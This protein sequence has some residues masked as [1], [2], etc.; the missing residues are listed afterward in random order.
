MPSRQRQLYLIAISTVAC[1]LIAGCGEQMAKVGELATLQRDLMKQY[2]EDGIQVNLTDGVALTVTF[3]NSPL[4]SKTDEDRLT[5]AGGTAL[6][7]KHHYPSIQ[8]VEEIWVAFVQQSTRYF[9]I[10]TSEAIE[11][12]RFDK[13]ARLLQM[14]E[15]VPELTSEDTLAPRAVYSSFRNETDISV[16]RLQLEGDM[17][18]GVALA[19]HFA[20][21]GD[22]S[23]TRLSGVPPKSVSFDFA[24]YSER[25]MFP[26][27]INIAF[28]VDRKV[29][30]EKKDSFSTS[31][32]TDGR[33]SEFLLL[34]VPYSTFDRITRGQQTAIRLGDRE[35]QLTEEH[36]NSLRAM[37]E[38][39]KDPTGRWS[40][41]N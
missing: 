38:Y 28:E 6:F 41:K 31:K 33:Y 15:D 3:I 39:L 26:G 9:I 21:A 18:N 5:R 2:R 10:T 34:Q 4:N 37:T 14:P 22:V 20:T 23:N 7:V 35:F 19:P 36:L 29:I 17:E 27:E 13:H 11:Y 8:Q 1:L 25:S 12:F 16:T 40:G 24:S 32:T 30:Y